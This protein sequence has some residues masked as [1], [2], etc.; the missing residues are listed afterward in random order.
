MKDIDFDELDRAVSSLLGKPGASDLPAAPTQQQNSSPLTDNKQRQSE[1][2]VQQQPQVTPSD[3]P[4]ASTPAVQSRSGSSRPLPRS[5]DID[6]QPRR[7]ST[8]FPITPSTSRDFSTPKPQQQTPASKII[9]SSNSST[10]AASVVSTVQQPASK[11]N[12][13][14]MSSTQAGANSSPSKLSSQ[15]MP[16]KPVQKAP[17]KRPTPTGG[18][19]FMDVVHPSA[20]NQPSANAKSPQGA[21]KKP[22]QSQPQ[23]IEKTNTTPEES[24]SLKNSI[25]KR[26]GVMGASSMPSRVSHAGKNIESPKSPK[27][28][29]FVDSLIPKLRQ[30]AQKDTPKDTSLLQAPVELKKIN[31]GKR[32][33]SLLTSRAGQ[34]ADARQQRITEEVPSPFLTNTKVE[35]RPLGGGSV[36]SGGSHSD[37]STVKQTLDAQATRLDQQAEDKS[38]Y[39][40]TPESDGY[41]AI[42]DGY[43]EDELGAAPAEFSQDV[44][45]AEAIEPD[46][47]EEE[48]PDTPPAYPPERKVAAAP[49]VATA[50]HASPAAETA[51]M[52]IPQQYRAKN[53]T[54]DKTP[55]SIY[56]TEEYHKPLPAAASR[57]KKSHPVV[58]IIL[59]ILLLAIGAG[60]GVAA[61]FLVG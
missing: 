39:E 24:H 48:R 29:S 12:S 59:T 3:T 40:D 10:S 44:V 60:L 61:Y 14:D 30:A 31:E 25:M 35:K 28:N 23:P 16:V 47:P 51:T 21:L 15:G 46:V 43:Y 49:P 6:T 19:R 58:W 1:A 22:V 27:P 33:E 41:A 57:K 9:P 20:I 8:R 11:Q 18:N 37:A 2:P 54:P 53:T 32:S 42:T 17:V 34:P 56:D 55:R 26:T 45:A 5:S 50:T 38:F 4:P 13:T 52:S 7:E 36:P